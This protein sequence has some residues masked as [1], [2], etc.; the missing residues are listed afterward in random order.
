MY[1]VYDHTHYGHMEPAVPFSKIYENEIFDEI[2]EYID[3]LNHKDK[4][5]F[6]IKNNKI[7]FDTTQ[8]IY[9]SPDGGKTVYE[10]II[11]CKKR[12]QI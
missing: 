8:K 5:Y 12:K 4:I 2:I 3:N 7:L 10:R 11:N 1:K 9:E 6:V